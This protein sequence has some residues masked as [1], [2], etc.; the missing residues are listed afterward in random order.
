MLN[1]QVTLKEIRWST[2]TL[3]TTTKR[4]LEHVSLLEGWS[5]K[6]VNSRRPS[7]CGEA[8]WGLALRCRK[9]EPRAIAYRHIG[10]CEYKSF[11][12]VEIAIGDFPNQREPSIRAG[13]RGARSRGVGIRGLARSVTLCIR[14]HKFSNCNFLIARVGRQVSGR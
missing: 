9:E 10:V 3:H 5:P 7:D 8:V 13:T 4:S 12:L 11:E 1:H 14:N 6:L 2:P